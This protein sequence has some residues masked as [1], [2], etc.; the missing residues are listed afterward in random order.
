MADVAPDNIGPLVRGIAENRHAQVLI[1]GGKGDNFPEPYRSH[2]Q[3]VIWDS[4]D[5]DQVDRQDVPMRV[6]LVVVTRF[7]RHETMKRL[8]TLSQQGRFV[9]MMGL[10]G[11]GEIK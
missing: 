11:T 5:S 9:L 8:R 4:K 1:V 7:I 10:R 6:K 2:P 3:I